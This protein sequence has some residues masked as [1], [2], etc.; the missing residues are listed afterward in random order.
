MMKEVAFKPLRRAE[1]RSLRQDLEMGRKWIS[2][3]R[4]RSSS[5]GPEPS[6]GREKA[7]KTI[8]CPALERCLRT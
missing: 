5:E 2:A 6:S 4:E 8:S 7:H 3:Q 1:T